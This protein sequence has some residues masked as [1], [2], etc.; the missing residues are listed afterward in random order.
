MD[1]DKILESANE[2]FDARKADAAFKWLLKQAPP[3]PEYVSSSA[4][5]PEREMYELASAEYDN[6]WRGAGESVASVEQ[7]EMFIKALEHDHMSKVDYVECRNE[8][9]E[10]L[11]S[12]GFL[13]AE[14]P[15]EQEYKYVYDT[16]VFQLGPQGGDPMEA[17]FVTWVQSKSGSYHTDWHLQHDDFYCQKGA[18]KEVILRVGDVIIPSKE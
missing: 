6:F 9:F 11:E 18:T 16:K 2:L 3:C 17:V 4:P 14:P 12:L 7:A 8:L 10:L 15:S 1:N 5:A 13:V